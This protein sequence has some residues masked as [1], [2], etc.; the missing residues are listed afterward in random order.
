VADCMPGLPPCV[1]PWVVAGAAVLSSV[2]VA[3]FTGVPQEIIAVIMATITPRIH[4]LLKRFIALSP[5]R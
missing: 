2:V 3:C 5:P 4:A 1:L